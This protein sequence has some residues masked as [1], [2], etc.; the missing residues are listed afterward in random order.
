MNRQQFQVGENANQIINVSIGNTQTNSIGNN[1]LE[2]SGFMYS[3]NG[4]YTN[5]G[6]GNGQDYTITSGS[7]AFKTGTIGISGYVGSSNFSV[8][9]NE[10]AASIAS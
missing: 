7:G 2:K 4:A 1:T 10:Y 6:Y 5:G 3:T 9:E 8:T